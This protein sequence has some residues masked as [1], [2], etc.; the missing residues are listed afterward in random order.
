MSYIGGELTVSGHG[1]RLGQ[2]LDSIKGL[3][4]IAIDAPPQSADNR[5]FDDIGPASA[6]RVL[7]ILLDGSNVNYVLVSSPQDSQ[8]VQQL[9]LTARTNE[10]PP[11]PAGAAAGAMA[12]QAGGPTLYGA[13][14]GGGEVPVVQPAAVEA[15]AD[16]GGNGIPTNV[17]IQQ[18]AT[19][20]G[21]TPG[22]I[23]DELQKK[24]LQELDAQEAAQAAQQ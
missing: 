3:T 20:S 6:R 5:I 9:I 13:G 11:V 18:A 24:Q 10:P 2:I 17:N 8:H 14:F 7:E 12:E 4:G 22:Q 16:P 15:V 21:K 23:L 19:A 1:A